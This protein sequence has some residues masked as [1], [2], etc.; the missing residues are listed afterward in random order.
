MEKII[1]YY[2]QLVEENRIKLSFKESNDLLNNKSAQNKELFMKN[3]IYYVYRVTLAIY[4]VYREAFKNN[5]YDYEDF[6]SDAYLEAEKLYNKFNCNSDNPNDNIDNFENIFRRQVSKLLSKTYFINI[7]IT[8]W[9]RIMEILKAKEAM[10]RKNGFTPNSLELNEETGYS[11]MAIERALECVLIDDSIVINDFEEQAISDVESQELYKDL[12][13]ISR[14]TDKGLN[15]LCLL[16]GVNIW[17]KE[18]LPINMS[19]LA[20]MEHLSRNAIHIRYKRAV[21]TIRNDTDFVK[22][23]TR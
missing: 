6:F 11:I 16:Y 19:H 4:S 3:F 15:T 13:S 23:Y 9:Y 22:K 2:N 8:T 18:E 21:E 10:F 14:L 1:A 20:Q 5:C 12:S 17:D 7:S